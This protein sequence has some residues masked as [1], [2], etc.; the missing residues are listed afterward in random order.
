MRRVRNN[1]FETNSSSV[2]T[3]AF[4]HNGRQP[5]AFKQYKDGY[6]RVDFGEFGKEDALYKTQ[7]DKLSYLM[8]QLAYLHPDLESIYNSFEFSA[9]QDAV[10]EYTGAKGIKIINKV[11]PMID[12]QSVPEWDVTIINIY[13]KDAVI[14]FIFNENIALR[15]G[16][17]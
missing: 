6:I 13:D 14:D 3:L 7:Y 4:S 15:T 2:H 12:H 8:T 9:I 1:V 11:E 17:D 10:C 16:C 5:S